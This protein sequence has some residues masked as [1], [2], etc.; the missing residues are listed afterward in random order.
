MPYADKAKQKAAQAESYQRN[1]E[2]V[3]QRVKKWRENNRER[4]LAHRKKEYAEKKV[5]R[6]WRP[7]MK[8][9]DGA[10]SIRALNRFEEDCKHIRCL[11]NLIKVEIRNGNPH[12][13]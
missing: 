1:R 10:T 2:A 4:Y 9:M 11:I 6:L 13:G 3:R 7:I 8:T 12:H 5:R